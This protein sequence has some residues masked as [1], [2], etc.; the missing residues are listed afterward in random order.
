MERAEAKKAVK[1]SQVEEDDSHLVPLYD[2]SVSFRNKC[3]R[4]SRF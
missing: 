1:M 3:H 2:W 4:K